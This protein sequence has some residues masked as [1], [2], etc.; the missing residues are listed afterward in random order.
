MASGTSDGFKDPE[1]QTQLSI[2]VDGLAQAGVFKT[3]S[4]LAAKARPE[5]TRVIAE[6]T[7]LTSREF[8]DFI[9][10]VEGRL[11]LKRRLA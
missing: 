8:G 10:F 1:Y 3:I 9:R 7:E 11:F 2:F 6:L 4:E 5:L